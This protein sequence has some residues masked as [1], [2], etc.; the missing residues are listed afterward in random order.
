MSED[1]WDLTG[2]T[3]EA[4]TG[5]RKLRW[6]YIVLGNLSE[7]CNPKSTWEADRGVTW[8]NAEE[9]ESRSR[10]TSLALGMPLRILGGKGGLA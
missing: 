1:S 7:L 3:G 6:M 2:E 9:T 8:Q 10:P 5:D 4:D